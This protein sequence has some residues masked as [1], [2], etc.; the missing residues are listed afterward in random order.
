MYRL[1]NSELPMHKSKRAQCRV[2]GS[3]SFTGLTREVSGEMFTVFREAWSLPVPLSWPPLWDKYRAIRPA[4]QSLPESCRDS[5]GWRFGRRSGGSGTSPGADPK[6]SH[7]WTAPARV[8]IYIIGTLW[9]IVSIICTREDSLYY[10]CSIL[11]N[12]YLRL[13]KCVIKLVSL[14]IQKWKQTQFKPWILDLYSNLDKVLAQT[15]TSAMCRCSP[16]S[17]CRNRRMIGINS[18][19]APM[20]TGWED[21]SPFLTLPDQDIISF[22]I[23]KLNNFLNKHVLL[24]IPRT[25]IIPAFWSSSTVAL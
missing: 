22:I 16:L 17:L 24:H 19:H 9:Y 6:T 25:R 21:F 10:R 7:T 12:S 2:E 5:L 20:D 3:V 11:Y 23:S 4:Q 18:W 14:R 1:S 8:G 15:M 13:L